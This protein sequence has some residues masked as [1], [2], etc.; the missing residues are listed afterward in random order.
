MSNQPHGAEPQQPAVPAADSHGA[1]DLSAG[2]GAPA[3]APGAPG[4]PAGAAPAPQQAGAQLNAPLITDVTDTTFEDTIA[5]SRTVPVILLI[6]SS[7]SLE[8]RQAVDIME[9]I[10]RSLAGRVQLAKA[11]AEASPGIVQAFQVQTLP[12][13]AALVGGRPLPLFQGPLVKE[14]VEPVIQDV[15]TAA[16]ELGINGSIAVTPE[17]TEA[18]T[19]P[20]HVEALALEDAG[21]LDGAIAQW[22]N[23]ITHNPKDEAAKDHLSRVRF[24]KRL[25]AETG[26]TAGTAAPTDDADPMARADALFAA[27]DSAGA[28]NAL[29]DVIATPADDDQR[30]QARVRLLDLL[31]V[32]GN[33]PE[34]R[35]A[36]SRLATLLMI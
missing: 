15:L 33:T 24:Q 35:A 32:E 31:R 27:G 28:F 13:L 7:T 26:D 16:A 20:E 25:L 19:P 29:L 17:Q 18:P 6:W 23:V 4:T 1:V 22:E 36:R 30:E 10:T 12:T 2:P 8:S 34:V 11:D 3:G 9:G 21:D 14:Q 5:V